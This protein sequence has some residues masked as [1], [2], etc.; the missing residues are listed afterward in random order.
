[1]R[2]KKAGARPDRARA[3]GSRRARSHYVAPSRF[4]ARVASEGR[5]SP[6]RSRPRPRS[7]CP[8]SSP[9]SGETGRDVLSRSR[10]GRDV[11][12]EGSE[13]KVEVFAKRTRGNHLRARGAIRRGQD[14]GC[15]PGRVRTSPTGAISR[16]SIARSSL[17]WSVAGGRR[18]TSSSTG[19][20]VGQPGGDPLAVLG[21][22]RERPL[23]VAEQFGLDQARP[24]RRQASR[25][26]RAV[27]D[28]PRNDAR[29]GRPGSLLAGAAR[30]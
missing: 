5:R 9:G 24:S 15:R 28:G 14:L 18:S 30:R 26:E 3:R 25:D 27:R 2:W 10:S 13:A 19:P 22:S 21:R 16:F 23:G 11:D 17:T 8:E 12:R 20:A 29:P 7:G 4:P 6:R 1:M